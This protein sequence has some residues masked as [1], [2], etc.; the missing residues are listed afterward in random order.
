MERERKIITTDE[1]EAARS[2]FARAALGETE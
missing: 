1:F 2:A